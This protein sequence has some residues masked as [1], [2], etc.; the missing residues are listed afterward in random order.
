MHQVSPSPFLNIL[1]IA[2]NTT[3]LKILFLFSIFFLLFFMCIHSLTHAY[4]ST[5]FFS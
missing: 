4:M 5:L 3:L 1:N 2:E